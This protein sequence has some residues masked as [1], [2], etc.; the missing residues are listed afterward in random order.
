[1][2][3]SR[4][5]ADI[6]CLW[7]AVW[8]VCACGGTTRDGGESGTVADT[9]SGGLGG[10]NGAGGLGELNDCGGALDVDGC[11]ICDVQTVWTARGGSGGVGDLPC[12]VTVDLDMMRAWPE[13]DV[14]VDCVLLNLC[15][16]CAPSCEGQCTSEEYCS[17]TECWWS[18]GGDY[19]V[20]VVVLSD[21]VCSRLVAGDIGR[22]DLVAS[23]N[24]PCFD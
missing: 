3:R 13:I 17:Q 2:V 18:Q 19:P 20:T 4:Q 7:L 22:V 16:G 1:M 6:Q 8:V 15:G 11:G 5:L 14:R 24:S 21:P 9:H 23:C 10:R 12:Q